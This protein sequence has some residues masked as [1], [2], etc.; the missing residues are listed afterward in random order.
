[1][2]EL[3]KNCMVNDIN[4]SLRNY[5][6]ALGNSKSYFQP[7]MSHFGRIADL[8]EWNSD[9]YTEHHTHFFGG[10]GS[11]N[12]FNL[13]YGES[14]G[15]W[16]NDMMCNLAGISYSFGND[17]SFVLPDSSSTI[18]MALFAKKCCRIEINESTITWVSAGKFIPV[19]TKQ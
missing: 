13:N 3:G 10:M 14:L 11:F 9:Q 17:L 19:F 7:T 6:K 2:R 4:I 1:M 12:H 8:E 18:W 15:Y 5:R 16:K